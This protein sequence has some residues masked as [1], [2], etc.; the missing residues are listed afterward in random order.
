ML[1]LD[2]HNTTVR[3]M[4]QL[5]YNYFSLL[6]LIE[7]AYAETVPI[8][9]VISWIL[10]SSDRHIEHLITKISIVKMIAM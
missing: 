5:F 2:T 10:L 9:S 6:I 7:Y 1:K 4:A 3:G 8:N